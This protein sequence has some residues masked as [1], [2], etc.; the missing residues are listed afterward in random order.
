[1]EKLGIIRRSNS[2]YGSPIVNVQNKDHTIRI[3]PDYRKLN[4]L[5]VFDPESM[6][7]AENLMASMKT[8]RYF[9]K[10]DMFTGHWQVPMNEKDIPK[11][12]FVTQDCHYE[13]TRMPFG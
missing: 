4:K 10:L 8:A 5:S 7:S 11:T 9:T 1:M 2:P 12:A 3:C 13:Y 6:T